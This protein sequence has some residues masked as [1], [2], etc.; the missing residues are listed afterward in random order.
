QSH[1]QSTAPWAASA[2]APPGF[3]SASWHQQHG[4]VYV[5]PHLRHKTAPA[6][7]PTQAPSTLAPWDLD[8]N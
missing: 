5:P 1:L 2:D 8:M 6:Q 4:E 7:T 3:E